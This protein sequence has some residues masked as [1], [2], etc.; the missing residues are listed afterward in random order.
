MSVVVA[1]AYTR[2]FTRSSAIVHP[3]PTETK[4]NQGH[5]HN[6]DEQGN[7]DRRSVTHLEK[8]KGIFVDIHDQAAAGVAWAAFGEHN[9]RVEH[10]QSA[11]H[12]NDHV[13][14]ERWADQ[15]QGNVAKEMPAVR[16]V[17]LGG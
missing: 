5:H 17:E 3:R 16:P 11:D 2:P 13:E 10:L 8:L 1:M 7:R 4:L 6:D 14:E 12:V 15:W 9:D